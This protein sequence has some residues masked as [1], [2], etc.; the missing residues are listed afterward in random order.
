MASDA[1]VGK[2]IDG[3]VLTQLRKKAQEGGAEFLFD[4]Y[5]I[6]RVGRPSVHCTRVAQN[7]LYIVFEGPTEDDIKKLLGIFDGVPLQH[8][9]ELPMEVGRRY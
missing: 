4:S 7:L 8:Q 3:S 9:D 5:G 1:Y 6:D 2:D